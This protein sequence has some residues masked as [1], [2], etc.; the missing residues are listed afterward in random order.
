MTVTAQIHEE[1]E[2]PSLS[3]SCITFQDYM[4]IKTSPALYKARKSSLMPDPV[5]NDWMFRRAVELY[6]SGRIQEFNRTFVVGGPV[7][8]KTGKPYGADTKAFKEWFEASGRRCFL[9]AED[10]ADAA[11]LGRELANDER[12][13]ALRASVNG[14]WV[15]KCVTVYDT[16]KLVPDL[17]AKP[18]M[19]GIDPDLSAWEKSMSHSFFTL[20]ISVC[21]SI[22]HAI[23]SMAYCGIQE[24]NTYDLSVCGFV[25]AARPAFAITCLLEKSFP[26]RIA[27]LFD[28]PLAVG[29][30]EPLNRAIDTHIECSASGVWPTGYEGFMP[31]R[32]VTA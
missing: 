2:Y 25:A 28:G 29:S 22:E 3:K 11:M 14:S 32:P 10:N 9:T 15:G 26:Y 7:N 18:F 13:K 19:F 27:F 24:R 30:H 17:I 6:A 8:D 4:D 21:S 20:N 23:R 1:S 5:D 12:F 31:L 16:G